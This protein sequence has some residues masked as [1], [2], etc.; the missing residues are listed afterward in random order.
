MNPDAAAEDF[1]GEWCIQYIAAD[2]EVA[3][4]ETGEITADI[5]IKDGGITFGS[6]V[7]FSELFGDKALEMEF[8]DGAYTYSR[9]FFG[10]SLSFRI[11][12]LQDG[13][14]AVTIDISGNS[15][16]LYMVRIDAA[17]E[18]PAA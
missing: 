5:A 16:I 7:G 10:V 9:S 3:A 11:E 8:S 1:N 14:A 2:G 17:S 15:A 12:M 4:N 13:M 18:A 6:G